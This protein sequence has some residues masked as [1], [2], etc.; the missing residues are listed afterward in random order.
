MEENILLWRISPRRCKFCDTKIMEVKSTISERD[1][2]HNMYNIIEEHRSV[3]NLDDKSRSISDVLVMTDK[4]NRFGSS[5]YMS[6]TWIK[7]II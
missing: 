7:A 6:Y 2:L 3:C 1:C 5:V 4:T